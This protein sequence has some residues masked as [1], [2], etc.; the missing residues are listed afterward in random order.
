M[1][2]KPLTA[3]AM[4]PIGKIDN[5]LLAM[6]PAAICSEKSYRLFSPAP[7]IMGADKRKEKRAAASL[8]SPSASPAVMVEPERDTPG[9]TAKAC[10]RPMQRASR[11]FIW[12]KFL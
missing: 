12:L 2:K 7:A 1:Q 5:S 4:N 8:S 10:A 3:A 6:V 9:M 11:A